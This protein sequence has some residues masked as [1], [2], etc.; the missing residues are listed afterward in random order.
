[1]PLL[2]TGI[3]HHTA[4][5]EIRERIAITRLD[6]AA[7]V[8]ELH[9]L[10]GVE[11]V[12]VVSTCNRTEIYSIGPK[13][14]RE[15]VYQW[16]QAKGGLSDAE[17]AKHCYVREREQAVRHLF[18]VAGGLESLVL[19]E[20]QI[21]GQLKDAWQ[22]ANDADGVG[23]VLDRLFQHAFATGKRI[24][25]KTHIGDHPVSVAYT[26]VMLAKQIFGDLNSKTVILVGAGEMV[27]LCG[28]HLH[29]KGLS[30][31]II[32]NRSIE[33]ANE[34]AQ[35]F[36]GLAV[37]LTD[38]PD[39]LHKADI[40]ISSTASLEPVLHAQSV[41]MALKQR[42]NQP[43]FLVDI[44]VP[45]DIHPDVGKLGNV[46]LYTIDDLQK[47][48]D[49]NLS[50][51]NEAAEAASGDIDESVDEFMR[52]L[53]S[54][55][56]AVYLKNLHKHARLNSDELVSRALRKIR[57]G[58]DPEQVITQL[59]NTLTKR[60]LHLPSTRLRQA[61]EQQDDDLL[62]VANRLFEPEDNL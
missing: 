61:A 23:K 59:A 14:S 25:S 26:T 47:V 48:V 40:L 18:R 45:R 62:R 13:Q 33:R 36:G 49:K 44:A 7:R 30:S 54:A 39:V 21:V 8:K 27:E 32:A 6:Y 52:W 38:L 42:R 51:R 4:T 19:G 5:L 22:M 1:M 2:I 53:N 43:M 57:A 10:D 41:K 46:Y 35:E 55:R 9:A 50:K 20:S 31:L 28:R 60:I 15:Q 12:V 11:E 17:M 16:L 3:S 58:Q 34:L 29:D 56:A 24:R 37:S